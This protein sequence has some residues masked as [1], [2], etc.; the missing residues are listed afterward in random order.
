M[1]IK[2]KEKLDIGKLDILVFVR[3]IARQRKI[4]T[5]NLINLHKCI[6]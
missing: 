1:E 5:I 2:K 6:Q 3:C 4:I